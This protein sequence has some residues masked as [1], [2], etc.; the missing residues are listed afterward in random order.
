MVPALLADQ[1]GS[2]AT[3]RLL[4]SLAWVAAGGL[5]LIII[6]YVIYL[7]VRAA[8]RP[9][10]ATGFDLAQLRR[11]RHEG[12]MTDQEYELAKASVIGR[13]RKS[14][15]P[16]TG[17]EDQLGAARDRRSIADDG[18]SADDPLA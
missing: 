13:A 5:V 7:R 1:S 11:M 16:Q 14:D 8:L 9:P 2:A 10:P 12:L 6:A 18:D 15:L 3:G 17:R 4:T